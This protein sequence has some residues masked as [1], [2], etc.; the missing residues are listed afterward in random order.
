LFHQLPQGL[1]GQGPAG[2]LTLVQSMIANFP[3]FAIKLRR[4]QGFAEEVTQPPVSP[5]HGSQERLKAKRVKQNDLQ[6]K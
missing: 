6:E 1:A 4:I 3:R 5:D 2:D